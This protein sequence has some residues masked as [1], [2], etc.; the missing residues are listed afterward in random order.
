MK[1]RTRSRQTRNQWTRTSQSLSRT[2]LSRWHLTWTT[3]RALIHLRTHNMELVGWMLQIT[4]C[5]STGKPT[6][7]SNL[8]L[9]HLPSFQRCKTKDLLTPRAWQV[10]NRCSKTTCSGVLLNSSITR[11][12]RHSLQLVLAQWTVMDRCK[13][14]G[15][16]K[17]KARLVRKLSFN[18]QKW[19]RAKESQKMLSNN[20][21]KSNM[22]RSSQHQSNMRAICTPIPNHWTL[23]QD[24]PIS[25]LLRWTTLLLS[26]TNWTCK[27]KVK[28]WCILNSLASVKMEGK[29]TLIFLVSLIWGWSSQTSSGSNSHR[30]HHF[31][32]TL[33]QNNPQ[34]G[35]GML[36]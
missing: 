7:N 34:F 3:S 2:H 5:H 13:R 32:S 16:L 14:Q 9:L 30:C 28:T 15:T 6:C 19:S 26:V 24:N 23:H 36:N 33:A 27:I 21:Y 20:W 4:R 1:L 18:L 10:D 35:K 12:N 31:R 25:S 29:E 11:P 8:N 22:R 17:T